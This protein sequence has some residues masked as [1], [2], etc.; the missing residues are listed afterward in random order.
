MFL[1]RL[2]LATYAVTTMAREAKVG[3][4]DPA[5]APAQITEGI[6]PLHMNSDNFHVSGVSWAE[7][8]ILRLQGSTL[9][10]FCDKLPK[11]L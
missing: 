2:I 10:C 7:L 11:R 9:R 4:E 3:A 5:L 1:A 6:I 8:R